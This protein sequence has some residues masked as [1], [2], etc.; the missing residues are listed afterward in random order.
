MGFRV[1][2]LQRKKAGKMTRLFGGRGLW[3]DIFGFP[4]SA[5]PECGAK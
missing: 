3:R 2:E 4:A 1:Y 5:G